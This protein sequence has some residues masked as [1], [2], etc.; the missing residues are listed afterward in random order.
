MRQLEWQLEKWYSFK[1]TE[2]KVCGTAFTDE[3]NTRLPSERFFNECLE[4][5]KIKQTNV[6]PWYITYQL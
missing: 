5:Q 1:E 4:L 3:R 6:F 2:N